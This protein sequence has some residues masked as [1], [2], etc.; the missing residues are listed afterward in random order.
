MYDSNKYEYLSKGHLGTG[1]PT[2]GTYE[3]SGA[4]L[5]L[6]SEHTSHPRKFLILEDGCLVE[7]ETR[8]DFCKRQTD[9]WGSSRRAINYPQ[10]KERNPKE[11]EDVIEMLNTA[12]TNPELKKYFKDTTINLVVQEY[13]EIKKSNNIKLSCFGKPVVLMSEAEIK[14]AGFVD[15][16]IID[17]VNVGLTSAMVD[18]QVMPEFYVGILDFFENENEVWKLNEIS[19]GLSF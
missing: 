13:F 8:F 3:I 7:L 15:Y 4:T 9:E 11:K 1:V 5:I 2:S 14:A 12:L 6:K 19:R 10:L 16:L 17:Q 18:F